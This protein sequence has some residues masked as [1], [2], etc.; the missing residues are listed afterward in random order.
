[1]NSEKSRIDEKNEG[2]EVKKSESI[3]REINVRKEG[4]RRRRRRRRKR[5]QMAKREEGNEYL[6]II[7]YYIL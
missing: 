2:I 5:E 7:Y 3:E 1:M 6:F 4:R